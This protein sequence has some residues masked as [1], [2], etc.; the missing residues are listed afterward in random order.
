M[1]YTCVAKLHVCRL[2][3]YT[4]TRLPDVKHPQTVP[5]LFLR[6]LGL[7]IAMFPV[8]RPTPVFFIPTLIF[9]GSCRSKTQ[10]STGN[11]CVSFTLLCLIDLYIL[12]FCGHWSR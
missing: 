3:Q 2:L 1:C 8:T 6:T 11:C 4:L 9:Y 10:Q 12:K 7:K 5:V